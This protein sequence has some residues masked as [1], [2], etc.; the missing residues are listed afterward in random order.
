MDQTNTW[1]IRIFTF[2]LIGVCLITY[3]NVQKKPSLLFSNPSIEDLKYKELEEKRA[4]AE[5]AANRDHRDYEKFGRIIF[6]NSSLNSY[7]ES[8]NYSKQMNLY[9]SGKE[10]DLSKWDNNIKD[11]ENERSKC[12][13]F[14]P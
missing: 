2:V 14:N 13:D 3:L 6:C 9:L 12:I 1:L 4:N 7:I 8:T 5:F 10:A 11:Y